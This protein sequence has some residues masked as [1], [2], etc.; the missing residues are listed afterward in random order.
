GMLYVIIIVSRKTS[1]LTEIM[2]N[3]KQ[4]WMIRFISGVY[5]QSLDIM[6]KELLLLFLGIT[7]FILLVISI[8]ISVKFYMNRDF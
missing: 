6:G 5:F 3:A 7:A 2:K 1:I 8:K 4:N